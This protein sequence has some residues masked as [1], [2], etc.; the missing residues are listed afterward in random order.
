VTAS[1]QRYVA[2]L[3]AVNVG[4]HAI[5][6]MAELRKLFESF[7]FSD[8]VTYIQSGNV[9]FSTSEAGGSERLARRLEEQLAAALGP[10][11]SGIE[12]FVRSPAELKR[13]AARNPFE[14]ARR[15]PE[16]RCHL[17]FLSA[18]PDAARREALMKMQGEEYRF[19]VEGKVLYYAYPAEIAGRRRTI[20]FERVLGVRGT[21]RNWKVVGKLI[22]LS[23]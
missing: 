8:V 2:L 14:P 16:Q 10:R 20:D 19:H 11:L 21:A 18:E 9:L 5:V 3:R 13:A 22:E 6:K 12:V 17:M 15:D 4:G 1:P 23:G 7:G